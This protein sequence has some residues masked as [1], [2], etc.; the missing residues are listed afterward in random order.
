MRESDYS[1]HWFSIYRIQTLIPTLLQQYLNL[2]QAV[3]VAIFVLGGQS[4]NNDILKILGIN[5]TIFL[6]MIICGS[7]LMVTAAVGVTA[8]YSK[9]HCLAFI[10]DELYTKGQ[11]VLCSSSCPCSADK[12]KWPAEIQKG[13]VTEASGSNEY[14]DCPS[15]NP[16]NYEREKVLPVIIALEKAFQ[17]SGICTVPPYLLFSNVEL[18][19]P[20]GNCKDELTKWI[21]ENSNIYA[22]FLMFVGILG[23]IGFSF[24]FL[25]FYMKK[26]GLSTNQL[27]KFQKMT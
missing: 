4:I 6:G 27:F 22:G 24:S 1:S 23:M 11:S 16:S 3:S 8:A 25:I 15:Y 12:N 17:C 2:E 21:Q 26:K 10:I 20:T 18:G 9:N 13:M 14:S 5:Q 19:P 7:F